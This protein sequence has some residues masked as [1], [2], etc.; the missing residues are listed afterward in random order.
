MLPRGDEQQEITATPDEGS[1]KIKKHNYQEFSARFV[2]C[3]TGTISPRDASHILLEHEYHDFY[4][5]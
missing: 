4:R 3:E 5:G 2:D 1:I